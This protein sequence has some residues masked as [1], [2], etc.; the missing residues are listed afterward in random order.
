MPL[1]FRFETFVIDFSESLDFCESAVAVLN[2]NSE[3]TRKAAQIAQKIFDGICPTLHS[4]SPKGNAIK[5]LEELDFINK[6]ARL[7]F[8][9]RLIL[10][11]T[12][13]ADV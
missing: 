2:K 4:S 11:L 5:I 12:D 6:L 7:V 1:L 10:S 13:E 9:Y 3:V 8:Y